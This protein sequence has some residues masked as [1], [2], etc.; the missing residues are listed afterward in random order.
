MDLLYQVYLWMIESILNLLSD[1]WGTT[2]EICYNLVAPLS[3]FLIKKKW[4]HVFVFEMCFLEILSFIA[5]NEYENHLT[6]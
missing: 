3:L 6:T 4:L 2:G 1:R 5:I